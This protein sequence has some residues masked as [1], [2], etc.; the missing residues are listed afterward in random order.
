[1]NANERYSKINQLLGGNLKELLI[2][3]SGSTKL[4]STPFMDLVIEVIGT[5][6]ISMTH[7][8]RLNG[9]LIADPDMEIRIN[10]EDETADA[11][12]YQDMYSYRDAYDEDDVVDLHEQEELNEFLA[13]WLTNLI[14]QG[15][16]YENHVS[17]R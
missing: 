17:Q 8:Y 13:T 3:E 7:Y 9:D 16:S 1:M 11:A 14:D 10:P 4:R 5:N 12:T 2:G 15:F 6:I